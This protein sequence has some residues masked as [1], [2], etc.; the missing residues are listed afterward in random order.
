MQGS[1]QGKPWESPCHPAAAGRAGPAA[2]ARA[3]EQSPSP[4]QA[5]VTC[6]ADNQ[7]EPHA[8]AWS[9]ST[10]QAPLPHGRGNVLGH[11]ALA[12]RPVGTPDIL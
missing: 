6:R 10:C 4:A 11:L 5:Q 12:A 3:E 2:A 8:T 1:R 7:R 9:R